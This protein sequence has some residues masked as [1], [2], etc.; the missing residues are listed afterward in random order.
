MSKTCAK[1]AFFDPGWADFRSELLV[2]LRVE[3]DSL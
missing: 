1:S 3:I 2:D